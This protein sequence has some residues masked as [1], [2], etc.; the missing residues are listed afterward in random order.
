VNEISS[1]Q[2]GNRWGLALQRCVSVFYAPV[3]AFQ[4]LARSSSWADWAVPVLVGLIISLALGPLMG[5]YL[6][7]E[8]GIRAQLEARGAPQEQIEQAVETQT[9]FVET[10][11][12]PMIVVSSVLFLI[13]LA[14]LFW[15]ASFL[16]GGQARFG[17]TLAV[18]AY[19]YLT[20]SAEAILRIAAIYGGEPVRT[21]RLDLVL[22]ASPAALLPMESIDTVLFGVLRTLN[23]FTLW[24][25]VLIALGLSATARMSR[26]AAYGLVGLLFAIY[27]VLFGVLP[28]LF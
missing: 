10:F 18:L 16:F 26:G 5:P 15:G 2:S 24:A 12:I 21:D 23:I 11:W 9:W 4:G 14:L 8:G 3:A 22:P 6:D 27:V 25:M 28:G 20:K 17:T 1:E 7:I 19:A 13:L